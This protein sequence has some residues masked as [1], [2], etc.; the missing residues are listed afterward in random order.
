[1]FALPYVDLIKRCEDSE[2][3]VLYL[4]GKCE[5]LNIKLSPAAT[6]DELNHLLM[7]FAKAKGRNRDLLFDVVES[8]VARAEEF[9]KT[10]LDK[11][12]TLNGEANS[13]IENYNVVKRAGCMIYGHEAIETAIRKHFE[14]NG[15][16]DG[17]NSSDELMGSAAKPKAS[18]STD[19]FHL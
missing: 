11:A 5:Y 1:V 13:L 16:R 12:T 14:D 4:A 19:C 15:L 6:T 3:K 17:T 10:Q 8:D 7:E 2:R 9:I 18:K